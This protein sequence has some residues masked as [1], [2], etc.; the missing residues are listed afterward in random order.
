MGGHVRGETLMRHDGFGVL[1]QLFAK[2]YQQGDPAEASFPEYVERPRADADD[3][4]KITFSKQAGRGFYD[5]IED[6]IESGDDE[7]FF[8]FSTMPENWRAPEP[9]AAR[10]PNRGH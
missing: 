2:G 3:G 10:A 4:V 9:K 7:P 8:D 6:A 5:Q 1:K